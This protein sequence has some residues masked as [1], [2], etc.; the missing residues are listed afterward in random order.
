M[1]RPLPIRD[2]ELT[3]L[4]THRPPRPVL[5][6]VDQVVGTEESGIRFKF[7]STAIRRLDFSALHVLPGWSLSPTGVLRSGHSQ[8]AW[9]AILLALRLRK[10]GVALVQT[11]EGL[12]MPGGRRSRRGLGHRILDRATDAFIVLSEESWTPSAGKTT[13]I[14]HAHLR[15]RYLGYPGAPKVP[16]RLLTRA[17][18]QIKPLID[19]FLSSPSGSQSLP[20]ALR[21]V[22]DPP[23]SVAGSVEGLTNLQF[24]SI[25]VRSESISDG[26]LIQE[27][28]AAEG[29]IQPRLE[30]ISDFQTVMLALSLDRPVVVP[31]SP[32]AGRL[33]RRVGSGWV[34]QYEE[35][36]ALGDLRRILAS[37][38][39]VAVS[40]RPNLQGLDLGT[41]SA[42][43]ATVFRSAVRARV[44]GSK[45]AQS[46]S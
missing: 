16:G 43:Y 36:L 2:G 39:G 32:T 31:S 6:Y 25:S 20:L 34:H 21:I 10:N 44:T 19:E 7:S 33:A 17:A 3:V 28:C 38:R 37:A 46:V 27:I 24:V 1:A 30:T 29:V 26:A 4:L 45:I 40:G 35:T 12:A 15:D 18:D 22:G 8:G 23:A 41:T 9:G 13:V 42:R 11:L 14:P 5:R